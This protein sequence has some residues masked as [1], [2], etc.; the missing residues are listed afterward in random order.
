MSIEQTITVSPNLAIKLSSD[1]LERAQGVLGKDKC[2]KIFIATHNL[3][4]LPTIEEARDSDSNSVE[5]LSS[6]EEYLRKNGSNYP[7]DVRS[8]LRGAIA[9]EVRIGHKVLSQEE[10]DEGLQ[11]TQCF[12][13]EAEFEGLKAAG[14]LI[15]SADF[16]N[17]LDEFSPKK[18]LLL[19]DLSCIDEIIIGCF[20][21][22]VSPE[23][24][25]KIKLWGQD[26]FLAPFAKSCCDERHIEPNKLILGIDGEGLDITEFN[27]LERGNLEVL[28]EA[29]GGR[30]VEKL[31]DHTGMLYGASTLNTDP[32]LKESFEYIRDNIVKEGGFFVCCYS[33]KSE[34]NITDTGWYSVNVTDTGWYSVNVTGESAL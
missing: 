22:L 9:R 18:Q 6:Y 13:S 25:V 11:Q 20:R 4:P 17:V 24:K 23:F 26:F 28:R 21:T 10:L 14:I 12:L 31:S 27:L 33:D 29:L 3:R 32:A 34:I 30:K 16:G 8:N 19:R 5:V 7:S 1:L 2:D 15:T